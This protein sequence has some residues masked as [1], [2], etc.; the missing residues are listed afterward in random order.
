MTM[1]IR[2]HSDAQQI[3][4]AAGRFGDRDAF[5]INQIG[6]ASPFGGLLCSL[7]SDYA[8]EVLP[9]GGG[10]SWYAG[11]ALT[12][13]SRP[14]KAYYIRDKESGAVWSVFFSPVG[15]RSDQ[16]EVTYRPGQAR[17]FTLKNKIAAELTIASVPNLPCEVASVR[18]ENRS[19]ASRTLQFSTYIE[20]EGDSGMEVFFRDKQ[21]SLL[22]RRPLGDATAPETLLDGL[23]LFH[24]STLMPVRFAV[25]KS[26]FVGDGRTLQNPIYLENDDICGDSGCVRS[27]IASMTVEVELP[28]EGE[29]EFGFCFGVAPNPEVALRTAQ[30]LGTRESICNAVSASLA[31]WEE[32][33]GG[34]RIETSDHVFDALINTWLPY[35]TYSGWIRERNAP[36]YLDPARVADVLRC[37]YPLSA[38]A[39]DTVRD[40]LL[41]FAAGLSILGSYSPDK[42]SLVSLPST[43]LL[44]LAIATAKY[45]AETG[46][47]TVLGE[48]I[49][50]RDGPALPLK[51]HCERILLMGLNSA[52]DSR[53][54]GDD[55]LLGQ[56]IRLWSL[57]CADSDLPTDCLEMLN[58]RQIER[59]GFSEQRSLPRRVRYFQSITP[60]LTDKSLL[61]DLRDY[62]G[63]DEVG[64]GE[65]DATCSLYS[66]LVEWTLGL[67]ST[68]E[69]LT[70]H[71]RLPDSWY[72]CDVT[73][74]F[75][76]DTYTISIRRNCSMPAGT[77]SIVADGEPVL[78][79]MLPY[80]GDGKQHRIE[81]AVG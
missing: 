61:D 69:G 34:L 45:V 9:D 44:W 5:V 41:S 33:C 51:E 16:Y 71:P 65:V 11:T 24:T 59:A 26:D 18:L 36:S 31:R 66:A 47:K 8:L 50:L 2:P 77:T 73:R 14:G 37:L 32:L 10:C 52:Q 58:R 64:T 80:F 12:P 76:G 7:G 42:R 78:G 70:L 28:I 17:V 6:A 46:D 4:Y 39:S 43:E 19:A 22:M 75:R 27:P 57:A 63:S 21:R 1:I 55:R 25:E 68:L 20:P 30:T 23:V 53:D 74:R 40:S 67:N 60:T 56:T 38:T 72:E 62:L 79:D 48:S 35:E 81:A 3:P 49:A 54:P 15:E 13:A 29:A